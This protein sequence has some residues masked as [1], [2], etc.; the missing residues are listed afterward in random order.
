MI[1]KTVQFPFLPTPKLLIDT[2]NLYKLWKTQIPLSFLFC[3]CLPEMLLFRQICYIIPLLLVS[4]GGFFFFPFIYVYFSLFSLEPS[5][6][7]CCIPASSFFSTHLCNSRLF[8]L[9][10]LQTPLLTSESS[11]CRAASHFSLPNC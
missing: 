11:S 1:L 6:V 5:H 8:F 7:F 4:A 3:F 2:Q 10:Q 9:S